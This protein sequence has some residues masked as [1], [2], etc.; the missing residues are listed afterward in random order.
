[1]GKNDPIHNL[2]HFLIGLPSSGKTT[3]SQILAQ[4][5]PNP[6]IISTDNIRAELYGNETTQG[7]WQDI[8]THALHQVQTALNAGQTII[9]DA[10]NIQRTWRFNWLQKTQTLSPEP[11]HWV[12]WFL[13]IPLQECLKR[14]Q[15]RDRQVPEKIIH[16]MAEALTIFPPDRSE[17]IIEI[18]PITPIDQSTYQ[19]E[20][21]K[22]SLEKIPRSIIYRQNRQSKFTLHRYSHLLDFERLLFLIKLLLTEPDIQTG[23]DHPIQKIG[24]RLTEK[25]GAIYGNYEEL[26]HDL[27]W[28]ENNGFL[29][30]TD[31][32]TPLTKPPLDPQKADFFLTSHYSG[33]RYTDWQPFE[34]LL[35]ICRTIIHYPFI[36]DR[37]QTQ[38]QKDRAKRPIKEGK[39]QSVPYQSIELEKALNRL[40]IIHGKLRDQIRRDIE[41]IFKPY[42][43]MPKKF[44][45]KHGYYLGTAILSPS[46]LQRLHEVLHS[47]KIYLQDPTAVELSEILEQ[48]LQ[49]GNI[50]IDQETKPMWAIGNKNIVNTDQL[51]E[52]SLYAETSLQKLNDAIRQGKQYEF[53][54][55]Y[56]TA[57]WKDLQR[58]PFL[59]YPLQIVFFNIAWY[60][61]FERNDGLLSFERMDRLRFNNPNSFA[62]RT[63]KDQ[64][65]AQDRLEKLHKATPG[66]FLGNDPK[67]QQ[68]YLNH[69]TRK[70]VEITLEIWMNDH[71]FKFIQEGRQRFGAGQIKFSK[72]GDRPNQTEDDT[73]LFCLKP[74][75]DIQFPHRLQ[76]TLPQWSVG[77][78]N[79]QENIDREGDIDLQKWILGFKNQVK[80][81]APPE[82]V[83][84]IKAIATEMA[85]IYQA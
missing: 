60:L 69:E 2:H 32:Q 83:N 19:P 7:N 26:K 25:H 21:L 36:G 51:P 5:I 48:R 42:G 12:A 53:T 11:L 8:E 85:D 80:V 54:Y 73:K 64:K 81:I 70:Q 29:Q 14:N 9:Y 40:G 45:A 10:T 39:P 59:A 13:D 30:Y 61:G 20:K 63:P 15:N 37:P 75:G 50:P 38:K 71:S 22:L 66:I 17:G 23:T 76:L 57:I 3:F 65:K 1:M 84:K 62:T 58:K 16:N 24:D 35:I 52:D 72:R 56:N 67:E 74:T 55:F 34:R 47:Q 43:L 46:E 44:P 78:L 28:L 79:E 33:H 41:I 49:Y 68:L 27:I 31:P 4:L 82:F 77:N 6:C 18:L